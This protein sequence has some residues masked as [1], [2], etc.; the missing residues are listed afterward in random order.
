[1]SKVKGY[2]GD[3]QMYVSLVVEPLVANDPGPGYGNRGNIVCSRC[4]GLLVGLL[5]D[6]P[7]E[8]D[9]VKVTKKLEEPVGDTWEVNARDWV[10]PFVGVE[11][12]VLGNG[13]LSVLRGTKIIAFFAPGAWAGAALREP[14]NDGD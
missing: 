10:Q 13:G 2:C 4:H 8:Y 5:S 12:H 6:E 7:G 3:C 1:M 14:H 11:I 9:I